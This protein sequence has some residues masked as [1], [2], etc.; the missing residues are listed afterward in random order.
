MLFLK[1]VIGGEEVMKMKL[2]KLRNFKRNKEQKL[3]R[4]Q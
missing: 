2:Q 4:E 1:G 3:K